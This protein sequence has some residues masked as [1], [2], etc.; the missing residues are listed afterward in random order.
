MATLTRIQN[1]ISSRRTSPTPQSSAL[2]TRVPSPFPSLHDRHE[3]TGERVPTD[4]QLQPNRMKN[5][6]PAPA[7]TV[8]LAPE[9]PR[10]ASCLMA[11]NNLFAGVIPNDN[12]RPI[13]PPRRHS[14]PS[15]VASTSHAVSLA[16][17]TPLYTL[18]SN[19][20]LQD[21]GDAM[22]QA[23]DNDADL[24]REL[25]QHVE[26]Y[27][28]LM[29]EKDARL[30][31]LLV[32]LLQ[33]SGKLSAMTPASSSLSPPGF[34][35]SASQPLSDSEVYD[36]LSRQA[37]SIQ[38]QLQD[39]LP[40]QSRSVSA[41]EQAMLWARV[42]R[43][44]EDIQTL[45]HDRTLPTPFLS[46]YQ[47]EDYDKNLPPEYDQGDYHIHPPVYETPLQPYAD[48]SPGKEKAFDDQSIR[49]GASSYR[50][51]IVS[52]E[53]MRLD[54]D[55]VMLAIDRLYIVAPQL[56][57]QRVELKG[58]KLEQMELARVAG[59]IEKLVDS[60]RLDD[61]RAV[62]RPNAAQLKGKQ[63]LEDQRD[64][65]SLMSKIGQAASRTL[66]SQTVYVDDMQAR[67]AR[68]KQKDDA[69][70]DAFVTQLAQ[71]SSHGRL[72]SQ[73]AT[74]RPAPREQPTALRSE[75]DLTS[76][77][78]RD[79]FVEPDAADPNTMMSLPEFVKSHPG[80]SR[81]SSP[82]LVGSSHPGSP[83]LLKKSS[84]LNL[85]GRNRSNSA[86]ALAWLT[87]KTA[88]SRPPLPSHALP[89]NIQMGVTYVAEHR[90]SLHM[91]S[92]QLRVDGLSR[93]AKF[94]GEV[95]TGPDR[96]NL[97]LQCGSTT[98][99]PL[100]L[101]ARV[102]AGRV[103]LFAASMGRPMV[104]S[105]YLDLKLTTTP[106]EGEEELHHDHAPLLDSEQLR[107]C[108]PSSFVCA[109]CSLPVVNGTT[110]GST[111]YNDLPSE[112]WAE[113]LDAWMCHPDQQVSAEI[114]KRAEG[115]WPTSGEVLVGGGY[116]LFDSS[117]VNENGLV[118]AMDQGNHEWR[119]VQCLCGASI[120]HRKD[121]KE[122]TMY[123]FR[124]YTVRPVVASQ[125]FPRIP[126]TAYVAADMIDLAQAHASYRFVVQDEENGITRILLLV[127]QIWLF[128]PSI[129]LSYA[130]AT[131]SVI[132]ASGT[133]TASK[134][135]FVIF[136]PSEPANSFE[137]YPAFRNAE[138]LSYPMDLCRRLAA[139]LKESNAV[140]PEARRTLDGMSLG[141]LQ[142]A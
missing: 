39:S 47:P 76:T 68:A 77:T 72:H 14:L 102:P 65:E 86:P 22:I 89:L 37:S 64:L 115:F 33:F 83:R 38:L 6:P 4:S 51:S 85:Q 114:A 90:E 62:Y 113:L 63:R 105:D 21:D 28:E 124:K 56:N 13:V 25:G 120:G 95:L 58:R 93:S 136:G 61:Q 53:K 17:S 92:L 18:V 74:L 2:D 11:L 123:R 24:L 41:A 137:R 141:W 98:L 99:S 1:L 118:D 87:G 119:R 84:K 129:Q 27:S 30:A 94:E 26:L 127:F 32:T 100:P 31:R 45:C 97:I 135:T 42:D 132:P 3:Q 70:R 128:K 131:G 79:T 15:L 54:L 109:S 108:R 134:V 121:R 73:D 59:A 88:A 67:L 117:V 107:A 16:D 52:S 43:I 111:R 12:W 50:E 10:D 81:K 44:L 139:S 35:P 133:I 7:L 36:T 104:A 46:P 23:S 96:S 48:M 71:H 9:A 101:P 55:S 110:P 49:Q 126:F 57:S 19:L 116:L 82:P 91:V 8:E 5:L 122:G 34:A 80:P 20:R 140:Y 103:D 78:S 29:G 125:R 40:N 60:G 75:L 69:K 106:T 66:D 142:R 130:G 112:H 138:I